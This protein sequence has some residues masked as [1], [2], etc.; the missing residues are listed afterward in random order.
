MKIKTYAGF[1]IFSNSEDDNE[2]INLYELMN[3]DSSS[4]SATLRTT[5]GGSVYDY[6]CKFNLIN[7][8]WVGECVVE[9]YEKPVQITI[10]NVAVEETENAIRITGKWVELDKEY[11][12][13]ISASVV[14]RI[15][16][17]D[18]SFVGTI[19]QLKR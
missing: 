16:L 13:D 4:I 17:K 14:E 1:V 19:P 18:E 12:M 6:F 2:I 10:T 11:D 15:T 5:Y 8:K 9:G 3:R 7:N